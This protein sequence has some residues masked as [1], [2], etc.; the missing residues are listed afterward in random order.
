MKATPL[1]LASAR[2][3]VEVVK[4]LIEYKADV[5]ARDVWG[6]T[7]LQAANPERLSGEAALAMAMADPAIVELLEK[8]KKKPG[9]GKGAGRKRK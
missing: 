6:L 7:P 4:R 2:G 8:K 9:K 1:H 5:T 3:H